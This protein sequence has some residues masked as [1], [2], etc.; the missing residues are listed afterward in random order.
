MAQVSGL[1]TFEE[2]KKATHVCGECAGCKTH[3]D[4]ILS[5][6]CSCYDITFDAVIDAV[7]NGADTIEKVGAVTKA[8]TAPDCGR[9]KILIEN[10][11]AT[12][13]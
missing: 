12:G 11:V 9:C 5:T 2:I 6:V 7:K 3:L 10:I 4:W 8:G 13:R 1:R